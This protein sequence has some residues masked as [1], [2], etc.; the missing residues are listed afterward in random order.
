MMCRVL[1]PIAAL[2]NTNDVIR[3]SDSLALNLLK[4][5][6]CYNGNNINVM[7]GNA[8]RIATRTISDATKYN[9]AL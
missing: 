6:V 7:T 9:T 2:K 4:F 5:Q 8:N 1:D 3:V